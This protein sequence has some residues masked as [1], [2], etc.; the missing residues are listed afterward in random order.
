MIV[1]LFFFKNHV[2]L[3]EAILDFFKTFRAYILDMQAQGVELV[4][5]GINT[6]GL[7]CV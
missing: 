4:R 5:V 2:R 1:F 3:K 6:Q 7:C